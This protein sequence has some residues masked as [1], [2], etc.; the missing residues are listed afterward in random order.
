MIRCRYFHTVYLLYYI[1]TNYVSQ[2]VYTRAVNWCVQRHS[3][4]E[5]H[6]MITDWRILPVNILVSV[7]ASA[8]YFEVARLMANAWRLT[9]TQGENVRSTQTVSSYL[10]FP[11]RNTDLPFINRSYHAITILNGHWLK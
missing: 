7:F 5:V 6:S 8:L 11:C 10:C 2:N 9:A 1:H 4:R 3:Q